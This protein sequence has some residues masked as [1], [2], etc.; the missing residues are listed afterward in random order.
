MKYYR[1]LHSWG[2][3]CNAMVINSGYDAHSVPWLHMGMTRIVSQYTVVVVYSKVCQYLKYTYDRQIITS[4]ILSCDTI[5]GITC[6][7][8]Y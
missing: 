5:K 1:L 2:P 7:L 3:Q 8:L 6:D 4:D